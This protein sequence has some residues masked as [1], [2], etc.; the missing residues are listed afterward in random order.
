MGLR[1]QNQWGDS[2]NDPTSG[3]QSG[4]GLRL[5]LPK[6]TPAVIA[7]M[8]ACAAL[9]IIPIFSTTLRSWLFKNLDISLSGAGEVWRFITFQFLHADASHFMWNMVGLYFFAPPLERAWGSRH[10]TAFYLFCGT[11]AGLCYIVMS[12]VVP[13]LSPLVGASGG[14]MGC[15][16]A[17]AILYPEMIFIIVPIRWA[18]AFLVALY[19]LSIL[20]DRNY[21][22]AAHLGGMMAAAI[23]IAAGRAAAHY[24]W[25]PW[26][27]ADRMRQRSRQ[28]QAQRLAKLQQ[29]ADRILDKVHTQG[30]A[31]LTDREKKT[32]QDAT[33]L[34]REHDRQGR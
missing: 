33:R 21:S 4:G 9:F 25:G 2:N 24:D 10:F 7:I 6:P 14:I 30:I 15:L 20:S 11:V 13:N 28:R 34:Q 26:S 19:L 23:W 16:M 32:L 22:D 17:C 5:A 27:I 3:G 29:E 1:N 18:A 31:S 8:I 12:M